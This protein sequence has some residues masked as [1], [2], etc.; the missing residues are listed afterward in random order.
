MEL[1]KEAAL[2]V[3]PGPVVLS[4]TVAFLVAGLGGRFLVAG[5]WRLFLGRWCFWLVGA[6]VIFVLQNLGR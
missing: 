1:R 4:P 6:E 5:C 2:G 3:T